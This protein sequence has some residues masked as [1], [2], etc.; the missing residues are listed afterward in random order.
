MY[1]QITFDCFDFNSELQKIIPILRNHYK[2]RLKDIWI[3]NSQNIPKDDNTYDWVN[4]CDFFEHLYEEQYWGTIRELYRV[5]KSKGVLGVFV[6]QFETEGH[7]RIVRP[8]QTKKE[9]E[10]IGF[11]SITE[12]L[13]QK[14]G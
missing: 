7:V 12:Y 6:G 11:Q 1:K 10:S 4:S 9:L 5:L 13:Y 8:Q 3:G 2:D 14:C